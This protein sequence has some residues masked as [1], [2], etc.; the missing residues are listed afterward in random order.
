VKSVLQLIAAEAISLNSRNFAVR[1]C[2]I[3]SLMSVAGASE[4]CHQDVLFNTASATTTDGEM[5]LDG[6]AVTLMAKVRW[7]IGFDKQ[8]VAR[9]ANDEWRIL[10]RILTRFWCTAWL[11]IKWEEM[12]RKMPTSIGRII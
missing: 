12:Y 1:D 9:D 5:I 11:E 10:I 2:A 6:L 8:H 7:M 3:W 4:R